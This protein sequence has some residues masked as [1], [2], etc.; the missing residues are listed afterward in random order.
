MPLQWLRGI[1]CSHPPDGGKGICRAKHEFFGQ[2]ESGQR[3]V[4]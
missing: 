3:A 4:L 1:Y 2:D